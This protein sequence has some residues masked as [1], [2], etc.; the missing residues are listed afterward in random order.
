MVS[1]GFI[2]KPTTISLQEFKTLE[3]L[4]FNE[5]GELTTEFHNDFYVFMYLGGS[6]YGTIFS[7]SEKKVSNVCRFL[8]LDSVVEPGINSLLNISLKADIVLVHRDS[9]TFFQVKSSIEGMKKYQEKYLGK[10]LSTSG[11]KESVFNQLPNIPDSYLA[12]GC[13]Y[14]NSKQGE[15]TLPTFLNALSEWLNIPLNPE[16]DKILKVLSN[17]KTPYPVKVL[18]RI[19]NDKEIMVKVDQCRSI[20]PIRVVNGYVQLS[21]PRQKQTIR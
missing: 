20:H 19:F 2:G 12:P 5:K 1:F 17:A 6:D 11:F 15:E 3:C 7:T 4:G 16:Y 8:T 10:Q 13:M 14:L 21:Q 18:Q 9:A